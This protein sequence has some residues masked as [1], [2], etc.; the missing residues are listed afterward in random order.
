M[1][2]SQSPEV[3]VSE[4]RASVRLPIGGKAAHVET[5]QD[6]Q[7]GLLVPPNGSAALSEAI[8]RL[9]RDPGFA[10]QSGN[11]GRAHVAAEFSFQR[12]I[13]NTDQMYKE[14]LLARGVE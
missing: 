2:Q 8:L 3:L 1:G 6:G 12:L 5:V 13:E 4:S 7:T 9:L 14:L 11:N 10:A